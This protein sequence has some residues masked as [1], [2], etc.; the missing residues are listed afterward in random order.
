ME[1]TA[2]TNQLGRFIRQERERQGLSIRRLA[3]TAGVDSTW[4]S[5]LERGD[6]ASPDPRHLRELAR[7]LEID[8]NDVFAMAGYTGGEG[9]PNFAP[10]LRAKYDLP[11]EAIET[12]SELFEFINDKY[13]KTEE[14]DR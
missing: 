3:T 10:Y 8:T 14:Q 4:L 11:V 2:D 12:L 9:L 6:Y 13:S 7:V 5:R 1:P